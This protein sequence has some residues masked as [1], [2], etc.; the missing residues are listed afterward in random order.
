MSVRPLAL[1]ALVGLMATAGSAT[2]RK[3]RLDPE[4]APRTARDVLIENRLRPALGP[5]FVCMTTPRRPERIVF[6]AD[7]AALRRAQAVFRDVPGGVRTSEARIARRADRR[8][9]VRT[10]DLIQAELERTAPPTN[11]PG[12]DFLVTTGD[13]TG[14]ACPPVVIGLYPRGQVNPATLRWAEHA[15]R[16]WGAKRVK[17]RFGELPA[18]GTA[19]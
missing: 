16:R 11:R 14:R 18:R 15:V 2:A 6:V 8:L 17:L 4:V 13:G 19:A 5:R 1:I 3:P 7:R 9:S 10:V 12:A